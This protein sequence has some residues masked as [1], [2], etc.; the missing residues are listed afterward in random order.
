MSGA[1]AG[2]YMGYGFVLHPVYLGLEGD[3]DYDNDIRGDYHLPND[4]AYSSRVRWLASLRLRVRLPPDN[5]LPYIT[6]GAVESE[7]DNIYTANHV[8]QS[9]S[10][11]KAGWTAG[12]GI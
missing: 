7:R 6:G 11:N 5:F 3:F 1:G 4:Q 12:G 9:L 8:D 2:S 10:N